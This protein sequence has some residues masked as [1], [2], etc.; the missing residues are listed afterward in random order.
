MVKIITEVIDMVN[1]ARTLFGLDKKPE[2]IEE[3]PEP[4]EEKPDPRLERT[5]K[6]VRPVKLSEK[7][8]EEE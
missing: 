3:K 7:S 2:P 8:E 5:S 1:I 6:F 4:I